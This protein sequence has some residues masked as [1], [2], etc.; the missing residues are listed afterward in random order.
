MKLIFAVVRPSMIDRI[1]AG[2]EEIEGFPGV[3]ISG[4]EGFGRQTASGFRTEVDPMKPAK[5]IQIAAN[6]DMVER[7][8]AVLRDGGHTGKRGDG[9]VVV[10]PVESGFH[11]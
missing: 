6:D 2:L 1:V 10:L 11:I 8:V 5:Q 4:A 7:I 9:I 3:T